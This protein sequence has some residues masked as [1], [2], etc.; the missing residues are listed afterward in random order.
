MIMILTTTVAAA[1]VCASALA[2]APLASAD[3]GTDYGDTHAGPVCSTL[4]QYP[5][6][7]G[8]T[9]IAQAIHELDGL[10]YY[11]AGE[12]IAEAVYTQCPQF[13]GLIQA[14]THAGTTQA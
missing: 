13:V 3:V 12:A 4:A 9:G 2:T 14:F 6:F 10:S 5:S 11:Q 8:L 1:L 7:G